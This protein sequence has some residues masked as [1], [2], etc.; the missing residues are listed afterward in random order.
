MLREMFDC[1]QKIAIPEE[2]LIEGLTIVLSCPEV[3]SAFAYDWL[4]ENS[5][6]ILGPVPSMIQRIFEYKPEFAD[7][8]RASNSPIR[9]VS[10]LFWHGPLSDW[11]RQYG[12]SLMRCAQAL[13]PKK[14]PHD[15]WL[16]LFDE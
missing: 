9:L 10:S 6:P 12:T 4:S 2:A 3:L 7:L 5:S 1:C 15:I 14:E 16:D 13:D 11:D 8:L